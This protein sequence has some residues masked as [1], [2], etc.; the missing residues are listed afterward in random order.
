MSRAKLSVEE[1][2]RRALA[3]QR[4]YRARLRAE[5]KVSKLRQ[6]MRELA[7][8]HECAGLETTIRNARSNDSSG[9][10]RGMSEVRWR[11]E[12]RRRRAQAFY[13][14]CSDPDRI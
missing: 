5:G 8:A 2:K 4:L 10:P 11:I 1:K 6:D 7:Y 9:K 13:R 14:L 3:R 12:Q